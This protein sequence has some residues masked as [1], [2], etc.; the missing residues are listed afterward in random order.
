M[1]D[2]WKK[3]GQGSLTPFVQHLRDVASNLPRLNSAGQFV[4]LPK[5]KNGKNISGPARNAVMQVNSK[6]VLLSDAFDSLLLSK[7]PSK[8]YYHLRSPETLAKERLLHGMTKSSMAE[9]AACFQ[10]PYNTIA[11]FIGP[12]YLCREELLKAPNFQ[13]K[14]SD[15]TIV[16]IKPP[17]A[18][19]CNN[20]DV[21]F[22]IFEVSN[23][24]SMPCSVLNIDARK[25]SCFG[26]RYECKNTSCIG[27]LPK[28]EVCETTGDITKLDGTVWCRAVEIAPVHTFISWNSHYLRQ[29]PTEVNELFAVE[30]YGLC[31]SADES[32]KLS[33]EPHTLPSPQLTLEILDTSRNF[34]SIANSLST[35]F[36]LLQEKEYIYFVKKT[37]PI[38]NRL[39]QSTIC[40][41]N[42]GRLVATRM[43]N[44]QSPSL[45]WPQFDRIVFAKTWSPPK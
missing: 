35:A 40:T 24:S 15:G 10:L 25:T 39:V 33:A 38:R 30:A 18:W 19:C 13:V 37:P 20:A 3:V 45:V 23:Q 32:Y 11:L 5:D 1:T 17:C 21:H 43:A 12:E 8:P 44:Q 42:D 27:K 9:A 4:L 7:L 41:T 29:L 14:R 22:K 16:G 36:D 28:G 34:S 6:H 31:I 2:G 26:A